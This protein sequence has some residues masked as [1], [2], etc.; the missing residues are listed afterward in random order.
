MSSTIDHWVQVR[1]ISREHYVRQFQ[2]VSFRQEVAESLYGVI[3][4]HPNVIVS[5]PFVRDRKSVYFT[6]VRKQSDL[7]GLIFNETL[8]SK[9][10]TSDLRTSSLNQAQFLQSLRHP[11][12]GEQENCSPHALISSL[13]SS[14]SWI[15]LRQ[16]YLE[17]SMKT[18]LLQIV[19]IHTE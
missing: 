14:W 2:L 9:T 13:Q 10:S 15:Q 6:T 17:I 5:A 8:Q 7:P 19:F 16:N 3:E 4:R 12:T 11:E 18:G 1:Y